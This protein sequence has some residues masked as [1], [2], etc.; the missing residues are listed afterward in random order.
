MARRL[1]ARFLEIVLKP[2][3]GSKA[4]LASGAIFAHQRD[5]GWVLALMISRR[6]MFRNISVRIDDN[7][8]TSQVENE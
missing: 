4:S 6:M 3:V 8:L 7:L 5:S 2:P 1:V